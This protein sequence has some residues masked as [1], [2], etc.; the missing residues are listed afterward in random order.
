M[1]PLG[2][3]PNAEAPWRTAS[4]II[5]PI[6]TRASCS[7]SDGSRYLDSDVHL[8]PYRPGRSPDWIQLKNPDAPAAIRVCWSGKYSKQQTDDGSGSAGGMPPTRAEV[9]RRVDRGAGSDSKGRLAG[10][11]R[12]VGQFSRAA[13]RSRAMSRIMKPRLPPGPL[14]KRRNKNLLSKTN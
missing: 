6:Q 11:G 1:L 10:L 8:L 7:N 2:R 9:H 12:A 4:P 13:S 3:Y 5:C 14:K